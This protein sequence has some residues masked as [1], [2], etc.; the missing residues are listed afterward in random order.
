M[1]RDRSKRLVHLAITDQPDIQPRVLDYPQCAHDR[2]VDPVVVVA[3]YA[4]AH[5]GQQH[6]VRPSAVRLLDRRQQRRLV[7]R[8]QDKARE[9]LPRRRPNTAV[10]NRQRRAERLRDMATRPVEHIGHLHM[11]V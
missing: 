8:L 6:D 1:R 11:P 4:A 9:R 3:E 5:A 7:R 2:V 10:R